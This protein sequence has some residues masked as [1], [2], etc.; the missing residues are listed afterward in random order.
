[1]APTSSPLTPTSSSGISEDA[2]RFAPGPSKVQDTFNTQQ[3]VLDQMP[4]PATV[5]PPPAE[6]LGGASGDATSWFGPE[7]GPKPEPD[8]LIGR[9]WSHP[10]TK[11]AVLVLASVVAVVLIIWGLRIATKSPS[12]GAP[13]VTTTTSSP[14]QHAAQVAP[15][16]AAELT[17][18]E[19]YAAGLKTANEAAASGFVGKGSSGRH[20]LTQTQ[21][22]EVVTSYGVALNLYD[23]QLHFIQWPAS[24]QTAI[25]VDHAQFKA[26]MSF[27]QSF[28]VVAPAGMSAWL[29]QLHDRTRTTETA[30][31]QIRK[32]LGLPSS[33]S[34]P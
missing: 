32:D 14:A 1:M 17:K 6:G 33:S 26:L 11:A 2:E 23:F 25:A 22:A 18:Y 8:H 20:A 9:L 7:P 10:R 12:S 24:M 34:F 3:V 4:R 15:I 30:D 27:L 16:S 29:T 28:N 13:L 19:G 31:N 5:D 21:V